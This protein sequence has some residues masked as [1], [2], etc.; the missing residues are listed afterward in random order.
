MSWL[1]GQNLAL[2]VGAVGGAGLAHGV[3]TTREYRRLPGRTGDL[4]NWAFL[5]DEHVVLQKDGALLIGW[6]YRGP[7]IDGA[8]PDDLAALTTHLNDALRPFDDGWMLHVDAIREAARAYPASQFPTAVMTAIDQE[9]REASTTWGRQYETT[10]R[11]TLTYLPPPDTLDRAARWF[12]THP[13]TDVTDV[14]RSTDRHAPQSALWAQHLAVF[15]RGAAA[16]EARLR[17]VL[18]ITRLDS[19][20]LLTHLHQ[21][22]TGLAHPVRLSGQHAPLLYLDA[23]LA[24]RAV[25]GGFAPR[26]GDLHLRVVAIESY[27]EASHAGVLDVLNRLPCAFRWS[28]RII[29]MGMHTAAG[30]IRRQQLTWFKKRRGATDWLRQMASKDTTA[31][32][33]QDDALFRDQHAHVMAE[34]AAHAAAENASGDVTF[35]AINQ[36]AVVFEPSAEAADAVAQALVKT[37]QDHGCTARLET[38]NALDAFLGTL[39]G[40]GTPNL[41][42][43]I[44]HTRNVAD[45]IPVTSVWPGLAENPSPYFPVHSPPLCWAKAAGATPFRVNLHSGDVGHTLIVGPSGSGKSTLIGLLAAQFP[46]YRD[47][48]VFVFDV[49]YSGW[50]LAAAAEGRHYDI[51]SGST[52]TLTFQPLAALTESSER[53]WAVEWLDTLATLQGVNVTP[54]RRERLMRAVTLVARNAPAHRTL[55][56]LVV[57]LQDVE[58]AHA[59]RTYTSVGPYGRLLDADHDAIADGRYQVFELKHLIELDDKILVPTLLYLFHQIERRLDGSPT[60]IVIEELWAPLMRTV[61]A[62]KIAQWLLTLRKQN[63]AVVLAAHSLAQFADVPH[64]TVLLDAC[65]TKIYLANA[66][67]TSSR[68]VPLYRDVGLNDREIALIAAGRPKQDYYFTAPSG[69]RQFELALGPLARTLLT[70]PHGLT[71]DEVRR[72]V[73]QLRATWGPRWPAVWLAECGL[74]AWGAR[75]RAMESESSPMP[76]TSQHLPTPVSDTADRVLLSPLADRESGFL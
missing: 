71:P 40:H 70:T 1:A 57:H 48:Q 15:L 41:R 26:I 66:Q 46:R 25:L 44:V 43:P 7:D 74:D 21:C 36:V 12:L 14:H 16:F 34:D 61:F 67:A 39:P 75:L 47:A 56:E 38:V 62:N 52:D 2:L 54:A 68:N 4:V 31:G 17:S 27:P 51:A 29:P 18:A 20:A 24:D 76:S 8:T 10:Y 13:P 65:P 6:S 37:L 72:R 5:V 3:R 53:I 19:T 35:C 69:R 11:L 22:F 64:A 73:T 49:G 45:L 9:R 32:Q 23:I 55:T 33:T 42:R 30:L 28:T 50:L 59:L 60:L 63:A 58:L